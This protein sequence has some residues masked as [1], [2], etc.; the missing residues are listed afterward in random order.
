MKKLAT[1]IALSLLLFGCQE[2]VDH[3]NFK[4]IA[5]F[6]AE[7]TAKVSDK[8]ILELRNRANQMHNSAIQQREKIAAATEKEEAER[9]ARCSD[10]VFKERNQNQ[11]R[12]GGF[13]YSDNRGDGVPSVDDFY[14]ML[15]FEV[16]HQRNAAKP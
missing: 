7:C 8:E 1:V 6:K 16:C 4:Q 14:Q 11:C 13:Y 9:A 3:D 2:K 5:Q 15:L 10:V 12:S